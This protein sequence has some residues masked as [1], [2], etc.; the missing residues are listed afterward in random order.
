MGRRDWAAA[1]AML[2]DMRPVGPV[3]FWM[4]N[5]P[6]SLDIV[7]IGEEGHVLYVAEATKPY[8]TQTV[9]TDEPVSW[10]LEVAAGRA[11]TLG[12]AV[13]ATVGLPTDDGT[14]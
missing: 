5:T 3:R 9:G 13:D 14:D 6:M 4:K 2:F 1:E 10:V 8:S 7:F 12:L 11:A